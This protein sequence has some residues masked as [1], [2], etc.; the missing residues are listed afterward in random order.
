MNFRRS[1]LTALTLG[2]LFAAGAMAQTTT[3]T[4]TTGTRTTTFGLTGLGSTETAQINVVNVATASTTASAS[5]SVSLSFLNAAGTT[6]GSASTFTL[7][8]GQIASLAL[9]FAKS[10]GAGAH[11]VVRGE[12]ALT[13]TTGV[14][15]QIES[16]LEVYDTTTGV[17]HTVSGGGTI[18][19]IAVGPGR[20]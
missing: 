7:T 12:V 14:P 6:I 16:D 10:G 5:C 18:G 19:P 11:T 4:P 2:G 8:S 20:Q 15:C 9:P 1:F 13:T 3:P 17:N